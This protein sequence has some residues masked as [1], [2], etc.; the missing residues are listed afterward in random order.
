MSSFLEKPGSFTPTAVMLSTSI[1][2][3]LSGF[4]LGIYSIKGYLVS[5]GFSEERR[6]NISDPIE[7]DESDVSEDDTILDHAPNW[8]NS[9]EAD[10]RDGLQQKKPKKAKAPTAGAESA[11]P[12]ALANSNEECKLVLVVRTDLGMTK[13]KYVPREITLSRLRAID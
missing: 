12:A 7:S 6:R 8:A 5:P 13:G 2:A 3:F 10:K 1:V 11:S 9:A 4:M